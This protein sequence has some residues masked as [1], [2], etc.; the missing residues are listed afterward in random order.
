MNTTITNKEINTFSHN[1]FGKLRTLVKNGEPW[2]IASDVAYLLGY[3]NTR[4]AIKDHC[5]APSL[6]KSNESLPLEI[7]SRGL[8]I[9]SE[10]DVYRLI[11]RSKL[12]EAEQFED[13][14][15]E[16]VLPSIRKTGGYL[17]AH[18]EDTPEQIEARAY[19][20]A[21]DTIKR[22]EKEKKELQQTV[23][24]MEPKALFVDK[25]VMAKGTYALRD[26][27]NQ[28]G[29]RP[30]KFNQKLRQDKVLYN[31]RG[32]RNVPYQYYLA[33]G[34]FCLKLGV[35]EE[36]GRAYQGTRVT[37]KGL[38]WLTKNYEHMKGQL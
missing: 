3:S 13:W 17:L 18:P 9:I 32:Q 26:V 35:D 20:L 29:I 6:L 12:P 21:Q 10:R 27:A 33:R 36:A 28:L 38:S 24:S 23:I 16:E 37:N 19:H 22:Q 25:Y 8:T 1:A 2:F 30:N 34:Y 4:K 11:F 7:P 31:K 5:K 14:V 15:V